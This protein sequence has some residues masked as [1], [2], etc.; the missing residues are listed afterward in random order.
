[1]DVFNA[2]ERILWRNGVSM[3]RKRE[4]LCSKF[5]EIKRLK[6][7]CVFA[8]IKTIKNKKERKKLQ[9]ENNCKKIFLG[10]FFE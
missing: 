7:S 4:I 2:L 8:R 3:S 6:F 1:M 9:I 5:A 10:K